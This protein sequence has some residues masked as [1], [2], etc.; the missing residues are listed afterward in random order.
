MRPFFLQAE[1]AWMGAGE[2]GEAGAL[3]SCVVSKHLRRG[4][5]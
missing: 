5:W 3:L 2:Q 1:A 4:P